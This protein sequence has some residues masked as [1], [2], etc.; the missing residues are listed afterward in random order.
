MMLRKVF[1]ILVLVLSGSGIHAK[2][3]LQVT[4]A[5]IPEAPP[6]AKVM[7]GYLVIHN[8]SKQPVKITGVSTADFKQVEMHKTVEKDGVS[9]MIR[10]DML[11]INAGSTL[12]FERGGLH[13]M[14][15]GPVRKLKLNDVVNIR[16]ITDK[17]AVTFSAT[18]K[19]AAIEDH[20]HHHHH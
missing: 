20:S 9:R 16:M 11:S 6:V 10:Q 14:L 5:W 13:L 18:I 8:P 4:D 3:L 17:G 1:V 15:I 2:E 7:A 19:Q 12:K